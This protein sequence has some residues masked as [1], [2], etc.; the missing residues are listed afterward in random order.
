MIVD[1]SQEASVQVDKR[2]FKPNNGHYIGLHVWD[3]YQCNSTVQSWM[4]I[5]A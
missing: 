3:M 4:P 5:V 2:N 1:Y